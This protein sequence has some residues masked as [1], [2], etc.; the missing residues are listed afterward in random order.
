M[1]GHGLAHIT[2]GG[3]ALGL[4]FNIMPIVTA[5][6]IAIFSSLGIL[7]LR[8]KAGVYEDTAI[9]I[10]SSMGMAV[11]II[12]AS[13]AG[14][15]NVHLMSYLFGNI[16]A[17]SSFE[18]WISVALTISILITI[19][20]FYRELMFITFDPESAKVHYGLALDAVWIDWNWETGEEEFIKALK[21]NP[22]D[23]LT[24]LYYAHLL[25]ILHRSDEALHQAE[26]GLS[27]DP[28]RPLVLGLYGV[29]MMERG[30]YQSAISAFD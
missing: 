25:M 29:V 20:F 18:L 14:S 2:F 11:G 4:F 9:A 16:L 13:L 17:I 27:L 7:K 5:L 8:K 26:I 24:R 3:V 19:T 22:N 23:A 21:L 6:I 12:L 30:N 28:L 15:F 10:F 1:I